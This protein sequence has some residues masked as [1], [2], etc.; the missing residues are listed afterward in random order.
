MDENTKP[1][2]E[3]IDSQKMRGGSYLRKKDGTLARVVGPNL[4]KEEQAAAPALLEAHAAKQAEAAKPVPK[5]PDQAA[6][7]ASASISGGAQ[8]PAPS[9]KAKE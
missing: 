3:G 7:S 4:T 2:I 5:K 8:P 6:L 9:N 1:V